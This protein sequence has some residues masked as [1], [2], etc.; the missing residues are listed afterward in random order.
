VAQVVDH[1][2]SQREVLSSNPRAAKKETK[3]MQFFWMWKKIPS[4]SWH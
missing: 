3:E 1:L 2:L 4:L